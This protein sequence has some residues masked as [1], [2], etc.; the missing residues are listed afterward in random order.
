MT[1]KQTYHHGNLKQA[2]KDEALALIRQNSV[3]AVSLR[4]IARNVGVSQSAPY[5]H[6]GDKE[7]LLSAIAEDG[8]ERLS[9]SMQRV[10]S[11]RRE[12]PLEALIDGGVAYV[13]F[14]FHY[15]EHYR[16]MYMF[17]KDKPKLHSLHCANDAFDLLSETLSFGESAGCFKT[18]CKD[19]MILSIWS[20]VHGFATMLIDKTIEDDAQSIRPRFE[21]MISILFDGIGIPT[22]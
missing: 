22:T 9:G 12:R 10:M 6:F 18:G 15:P 17:S 16:L 1:S 8:F 3:N 21:R 4:A 14:A 20:L 2:L 19:T 13:E 11:N 5:R 7:A